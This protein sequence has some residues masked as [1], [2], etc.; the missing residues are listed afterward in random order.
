MDKHL[1]FW[2][3]LMVVWLG[4][5][6]PSLFAEGRTEEVL[7]VVALVPVSMALGVAIMRGLND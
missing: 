1:K 6:V 2:I 7:N 5:F 3:L 4:F